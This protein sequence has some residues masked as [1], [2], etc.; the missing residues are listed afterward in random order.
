MTSQ[1]QRFDHLDEELAKLR[2][3]V[4]STKE[5]ICVLT[6]RHSREATLENLRDLQCAV[7]GLV[8]PGIFDDLRA[9]EIGTREAINRLDEVCHRLNLVRRSTDARRPWAR[10]ETKS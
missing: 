10:L 4:N 1:D 3:A 2:A 8:Y 6:A 7:R 9:A 5:S